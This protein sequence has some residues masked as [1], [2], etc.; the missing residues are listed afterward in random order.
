MPNIN[1][2]QRHGATSNAE[3]GSDFENIAFEYFKLN[4]NI[5]LQKI[6]F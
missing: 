2:N 3:V 1:N 4:E 5:I 6:I